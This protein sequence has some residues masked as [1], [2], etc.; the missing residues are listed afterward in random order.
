MSR[1]L[2]RYTR[3][4]NI[5]LLLGFIFLLLF[6]GDGAIYMIYGPAAAVS[7]IICIFAG[8]APLALIYFS[9]YIL[10]WIVKRANG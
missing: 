4:T 2:R 8:L 1:D 5:R 7:G 3:Q 9:L 10:E 6:V